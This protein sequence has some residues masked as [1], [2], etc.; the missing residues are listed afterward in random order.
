MQILWCLVQ[1]QVHA[2]V[3]GRHIKMRTLCGEV[4]STEFCYESPC[5]Y[6]QES[7]NG[8]GRYNLSSIKVASEQAEVS[9]ARITNCSSRTNRKP[10]SKRVI[11][12]HEPNGMGIQVEEGGGFAPL[13][14]YNLEL[15]E[16]HECVL[17]DFDV[18]V[19]F[20]G[21]LGNCRSGSDRKRVTFDDSCQEM[22]MKHDG[23]KIAPTMAP[24]YGGNPSLCSLSESQ[25]LSAAMVFAN[26]VV[27]PIGVALTRDSWVDI[28]GVRS[29]NFR[30]AHS[31]GEYFHNLRHC[32][33]R[34]Q[35]LLDGYALS[36]ARVQ[37]QPP[38]DPPAVIVPA[39]GN[40][41]ELTLSQRFDRLRHS[42]LHKCETGTALC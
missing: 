14:K 15:P 19:Q 4:E 16:A 38:Y 17:E 36:L 11:Q 34:K 40:T 35:N 5:I 31:P 20:V 13:V 29:T 37:I 9:N 30:R 12:L 18:F 1:V 22:R 41:E 3:Q 21:S 25:S 2:N 10:K 27:P 39:T 28:A 7:L 6:S 32:R 24:M 42:E 23:A 26:P 33:N 8:I